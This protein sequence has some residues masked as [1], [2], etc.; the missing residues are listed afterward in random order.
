MFRGWTFFRC[1]RSYRPYLAARSICTRHSFSASISASRCNPRQRSN[2]LPDEVRLQH[3]LDAAQK[4]VGFAHGRSRADL[5]ADELLML[6]LVRLVEIVGFRC[7][8]V[9]KWSEK[10]FTSGI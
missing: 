1:K 7:V 5:V 6:A 2:M 10:R 9:G 4:A 8:R 3:M